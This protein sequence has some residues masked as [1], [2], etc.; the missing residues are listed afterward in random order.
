MNKDFKRRGPGRPPN[1]PLIPLIDKKGVVNTPW[2]NNNRLEFIYNNPL[3]FKS[4]FTYFKNIKA[5]DIHIKCTPTEM[6]FFT[7]DHLKSSKI[8]AII[9]CNQINWYYCKETFWIRLN[10]DNVEKIF[11]SIDK[12][13][14]K[15]IIIQTIDDNNSLLIIFKD[16][17]LD[18]ECSYKIVLSSYM[19]DN[20]L[21]NSEDFLNDSNSLIEFV[22]SARQFK[23]TIIDASNY[24]DII[25][26]EKIGDEPLQLNYVRS[27]II[28]N[29]V[30]KSDE[31]IKLKS[32][33]GY[34]NTF[35][36]VIKLNNI[37]SLASSMLT[38]EIYIYC[39]P[40]ESIL[41]KSVIDLNTISINT[42][43]K[44]I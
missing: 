43:T 36:A 23:K 21:Y 19:E 39:K 15:I 42:L 6:T 9:S 14:F 18:K 32:S 8:F 35:R 28:Y 4:L 25:T 27:N 31:K 34:N 38:N 20:D 30:Y 17:S 41:F 13:F 22:L 29:E 26:F 11:S 33:I 10:R 44:L 7:R 12:T 2:D 16:S 1:K 37:K 24:S 40:D 3:I 5:R